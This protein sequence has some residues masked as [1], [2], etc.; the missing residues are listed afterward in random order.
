MQRN[1]KGAAMTTT[2]RRVTAGT[3]AVVLAALTLVAA[4]AASTS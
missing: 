4:I 1:P 3:F 2:I